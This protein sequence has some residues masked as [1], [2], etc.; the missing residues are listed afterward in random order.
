MWR[1]LISSL[2]VAVLGA[3]PQPANPL[4]QA[5]K[6]QRE[7]A[8]FL[9]KALR[10]TPDD[11]RV[12]R[13]LGKSDDWS[14]AS[15]FGP[16]ALDAEPKLRNAWR[17]LSPQTI[18]DDA[19]RQAVA[20]M[21]LGLADDALAV[22][23]AVPPAAR[24]IMIAGETKRDGNPSDERLDLAVAAVLGRNAALANELL[25]SLPD[26]E[27]QRLLRAVLKPPADDSFDIL[28]ANIGSLG[29][30]A[31][32]GAELANRTGYERLAKVLLDRAAHQIIWRADAMAAMPYLP[33]RFRREL[34]ATID[35]H[36][37]H[38]ASLR[39][40]A[41]G[42]NDSAIA[43]LLHQPAT[44][45][46]VEKT[47]PTNIVDAP[48]PADCSGWPSMS[49]YTSLIRCEQHDEERLAVDRSSLADPVGG[50]HIGGY[51]LQYSSDGGRNWQRFYTGIRTEV[52]Y[53]IVTASPIAMLAGDHV[54]LEA[55]VL[56]VD[57]ALIWQPPRNVLR[58]TLL[59]LSWEVLRRDSDGDGLTDLFEERIATDPHDPDS[60]HD[61]IGD[62]ID[63]LPQVGSRTQWLNPE[64][65]ALTLVL[66]QH[67]GKENG[68]GFFVGDRALVAHAA[69]K[70]R[71]VILTRDE[72]DAYRAKFGGA[73]FG[74]LTSV[75]VRH[76]GQKAV[77]YIDFG[78]A[79]TTY[80][81][82]RV[83]AG[84]TMRKTYEWVS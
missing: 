46:F 79:G 8:I 35:R 37:R 33:Q 65:Q 78:S 77:V 51:W 32:A 83:G 21:C 28:A 40:R 19:S 60:D 16:V 36:A 72:L 58:R 53:S 27:E 80:E 76:D 7:R 67:Y 3:A 43:M 84:W 22:V 75:L 64:A 50:M 73:T 70:S 74:D 9:A 13:A 23:D 61:G 55:E 25:A 6:D 20:L 12:L 63:L 71:L 48:P 82:E 2:G 52:P 30:W 38:R 5:P 34:Q 26:G 68:A 54:E 1:L 29:I 41:G 69:V 11:M 18:A 47:L 56:E 49:R 39:M 59:S 45:A 10:A 31:E 42:R 44:V 24:K 66:E 17:K 81:L 62:A 15:A 57:P 4:D 14:I